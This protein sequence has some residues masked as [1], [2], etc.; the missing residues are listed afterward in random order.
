MARHAKARKQ[1][2]SGNRDGLSKA[3]Q[4][5]SDVQGRTIKKDLFTFLFLNVNSVFDGEKK[6]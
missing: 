2:P 1:E 5:E 3:G 6:I 4:N